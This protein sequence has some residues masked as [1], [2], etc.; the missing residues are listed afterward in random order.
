MSLF[1]KHY[2]WFYLFILTF[3]FNIRKVFLSGY[4]YFT[5]HLVEDATYFLNL[6]DIFLI[7]AIIFGAVYIVKNSL[8]DDLLDFIKKYRFIFWA[9]GALVFWSFIGIFYA[10]SHILALFGIIK[11][12]EFG[13][14]F[15]YLTYFLRDFSRFLVSFKI[16]ALG[17][18]IQSIIAII[19]YVIQKSLGLKIL[20]ESIIGKDLP[21]VAKILADGENLVRPYGTFGHPNILGGFLV[22]S[23]AVSLILFLLAMKG[24]KKLIVRV[25]TLLLIVFFIIMFFDHYLFTN[26]QG[27]I[28][29]WLVLGMVFVQNIQ[30]QENNIYNIIGDLKFLSFN[31]WIPRQFGG[32]AACAGM[33]TMFI[34]LIL[35][36]S[37]T[38]WLAFILLVIGITVFSFKKNIWKSWL[39][40]LTVFFAVI[41]AAFLFLPFKNR[42]NEPLNSNNQAIGDRILGIK[43][44]LKIIKIHPFIGVGNKNY[45]ISI[46]D[47]EINKLEYWQYQP[48]HNGYFLIISELGFIG[49]GFFAVFTFFIA[50]YNLVFGRKR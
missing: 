7:L 10:K 17:G 31:S 12:L 11:I 42:I 21:G 20:G 38:A 18:L 6:S 47:Y 49:F 41:L 19:Q 26:Q 46:T 27:Q 23:L 28:I 5:G 32:Q 33:T 25:F 2:Y 16:V 22:F 30:K 35:T 44:A 14:L 13:F 24:D 34:A 50:A 29:F 36:Y 1:K 3:P 37:R 48:V 43:T 39:K 40:I 15:L 45:V 4:S 8:K 9:L